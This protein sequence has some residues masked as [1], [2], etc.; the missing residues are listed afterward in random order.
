ML[1]RSGQA[2]RGPRSLGLTCRGKGGGHPGLGAGLAM[3]PPLP[4][5]LRPAAGAAGSWA[6]PWAR[7]RVADSNGEPWKVLQQGA[8]QGSACEPSHGAE[9]GNWETSLEVT[10]GHLQAVVV[11]GGGTL[12]TWGPPQSWAA[13]RQGQRPGSVER[14]GLS[15]PWI[16][17][18]WGFWS[19]GARGRGSLSW[20]VAWGSSHHQGREAGL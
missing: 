4:G 20:G 13:G 17:W 5:T 15:R 1:G 10:R 12:R 18:S 8:T 2:G 9:A 14:R 19:C 11:G 7:T 3:G 6:P 16:C